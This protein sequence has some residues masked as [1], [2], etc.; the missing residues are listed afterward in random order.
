M[1]LRA[2]CTAAML[3]HHAGM[4]TGAIPEPIVSDSTKITVTTLNKKTGKAV[5]SFVGNYTQF[6]SPGELA[7]VP[8]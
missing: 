6:A 8:P 7:V 5:H 4:H 1:L 2:V 3:T